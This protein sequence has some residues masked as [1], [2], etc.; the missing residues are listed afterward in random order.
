MT[1][2]SRFMTVPGASPPVSGALPPIVTTAPQLDP[3]VNGDLS[4]RPVARVVADGKFLLAGGERF[5]AKGVTYGTFAPDAQGYQFPPLRQVANDFRLMASLGINTVRVYTVPSRELLDEA[6]KHNLRVMVGLAWSQHVAFLDDRRQVH[7]IRRE[8]NKTIAELGDH[9]AVLMFVLGNEIP[10]GV[11]RWHGRVRIERFLRQLYQ[12]GK[13]TSPKSLFT[14]GN[15]PPTEFLDLSF[16]DVCAFNVYLHRGTDLRAYLARLQH[17]AGQ[18]PLLLAEAGA[19]SIREGDVGQADIT[20]I[21]MRVAFEEGACGAIAFSWTDE[22]WR[23]GHTVEDWKFGLV[24]RERRFKPAAAAVSSVFAE[25]PFSPAARESWPRVSVVVCAYNAA[26]TL[27]D[28]LTSLEGLEYPDYE[29]ILVNDGS[30]DRTSEIGRGHPLVRVVDTPNRGLGTARNRGLS[31]AT[32]TLVAYTDADVRVDQDWLKFLVQPLLSTTDVV[33]SGGPNLV[34][35]DDPPMAQC[36]ARAPGGPTHVMLNDRV[37]EHVPGCNM[38]FRREALLA[39][40]GFDPTY[41]RAGD[42]VDVCWRLQARG[43]KIGFAPAALV[44]H[45]HRSSLRSYWKQQAGYGEGETWLMGHHPEKFLDGRMV[46]RGSIYSSV[47]FVRSLR[48]TRVNSGVWGTAAFPSVYRTDVH[49]FA[50]LPHSIRWQVLSFILALTGAGAA[51][52]GGHPWAVALLLGGGL[53]GILVTAVKNITYAVRSEVG[54]ISWNPIWSRATIACLHFIQPFARVRGRIRGMLAPPEVVQSQTKYQASHR[55]WPS[56]ADA[57]RALL[58]ISGSVIENRY[59]AEGWTSAADY[60]TR[61]TTA[62]RRSPA[63]RT[64]VVDEGWSDDRDVSVFVGRWG[65]LDVRALVEDHGSGKCLLRLSTHLRPT[66]FGLT[67]ALILG[68]LLLSAIGAGVAYRW[69]VAGVAAALLTAA[70]SVFAAWRTAQA[71]TIVGREAAGLARDDG[72]VTMPSGPARAPLIAPTLLRT[73]GL[74]S[75]IIFAVMILALGSGARLLREAAIGEVIGIQKGYAGDYGPALSAWLD[76]PGGIAI[77]SN[78]DIY[79][80]DSNNAVV[81]H[82]DAASLVI[83]PVAGNHDMGA[84]F[85]GDGELAMLAQLNAPDGVAIAPD[86]AVI[87][88]DSYNHRIRRVDPDTGI[89]TTIA[90]SG[91]DAFSGD[92]QLAIEA[93]LNTP[94]AVACAP[95]GDIY[96]ADTMNNRIRMI[97]HVTGIISTVAGD[98]VVAEDG[99]IGDGGLAVAAQLFMPSDVALAPNGDIYIADMH[100][101]LVRK[102]DARTR[103]ITTVAGD[104]SFGHAGD[105]GPALRASLAGPSG[106]ALVPDADGGMTIF[107]ADYYNGSIRSVEPDGTMRDISD[108]GRIVFGAPSRIAYAPHKHWLYVADTTEDRLVALTLP[109]LSRGYDAPPAGKGD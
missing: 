106:I 78:G 88:A 15:F 46:W 51:V 55:P 98:G 44:W 32:G 73:Y 50:H 76:T 28:C 37:A 66:T 38:A 6:A 105:D 79:F 29:I 94:V 24:D 25:V 109:G 43:W 71:A 68:V 85:A 5:L 81:R 83:T 11:V 75:A 70:G 8:V 23:G 39:I 56:L 69:P 60:L 21:Q 87:I 89:I 48:G 54:S 2:N 27:E 95:N 101:N 26:D 82:I 58:L 97:E 80:A 40:E 49:P 57:W 77:A 103:V 14:Y 52:S 108:D 4:L 42:D 90:G 61:L 35:V 17:V 91:K 64:V 107:I 93:A 53:V 10:P 92:G 100:H 12:E 13:A 9:P 7:S 99:P 59:W 30:L 20:A 36:I 63:V 47:P 16:L 45:H 86:G 65:W 19:D 84:G 104:G 72:M 22:W 1:G 62:L 74:R 34:P 41:L 18:R 33:G 3:D 67:A 31:E 96:I 102:V